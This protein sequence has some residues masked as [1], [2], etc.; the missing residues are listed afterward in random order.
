MAFDHYCEK[1]GVEEMCTESNRF[2]A[3]KNQNYEQFI[4]EMFKT[5]VWFQMALTEGHEHNE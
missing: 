3:T 1:N 2:K 5:V 4:K